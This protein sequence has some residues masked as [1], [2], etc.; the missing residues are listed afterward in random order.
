MYRG[1][2]TTYLNYALRWNSCLHTF[3]W[4]TRYGI[5]VHDNQK[6]ARQ[7]VRHRTRG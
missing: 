7:V 3:S 6:E 4:L 2:P 5:A 1:L